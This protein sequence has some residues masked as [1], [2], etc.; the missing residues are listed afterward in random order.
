MKFEIQCTTNKLIHRVSDNSAVY[1]EW[2]LITNFE[3]SD[4][5]IDLESDKKKTADIEGV[6]ALIAYELQ[7]MPTASY[8]F[9]MDDIMK[10]CV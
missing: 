3:I 4:T 7:R 8:E 10:V 1:F 2:F 6:S 5:K 9:D